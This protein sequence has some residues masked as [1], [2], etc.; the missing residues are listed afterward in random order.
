MATLGS[1]AGEINATLGNRQDV[2]S[3]TTFPSI[4]NMR[5]TDRLAIWLKEAYT[6]ICLGYRFEELE[7]SVTDS[8]VQNADVYQL[9]ALCRFLRAVTL[10]FGTN[11]DPRPVRRR[12]IRNVR[13]YS[14]TSQGPPRIYAPYNPGGQPSIIVR[15]VPDQAYPL[16]WDI[17]VKPT[18]AATIAATV[19]QLPDDWIEVLK[20]FT[21]LKGHSALVE[22]DKA[23]AA[24]TYLFGGYDPGIG[25]RVPGIIKGLIDARDKLDIEDTEYGLQ[26][27]VRRFTNSV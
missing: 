17:Q 18:F 19:I 9:P 12:H 4:P 22:N 7:S 23:G 3:Y 13:R 27:L 24:Q 26:P 8:F 5:D 11:Q 2:L 10:L 6:A 20:A 1:L 16:I 21:K 25:R 15:P 14:S